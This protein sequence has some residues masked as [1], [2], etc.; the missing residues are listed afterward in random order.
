M[1]LN[2]RELS[3]FVLHVLDEKK[4][5]DLSCIPVAEKTSLADY[6]VMASANTPTHVKALADE[7]IYRLKQDYDIQALGVEGFETGRWVLL[8][9]GSVIVHIMHKQERS[10]YNLEKFWEGKEGEYL[11][12]LDSESRESSLS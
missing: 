5:D 2:S 10:F 4:A 6:F 7:L 11:S 12:P 3:E 1:A 9:L 8:D